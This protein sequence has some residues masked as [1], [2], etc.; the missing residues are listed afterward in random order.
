MKLIPRPDD[1]VVSPI[2]DPLMTKGGLYIPENAR[3]K[4]DQGIIISIGNEVREDLEIGDH[5]IFPA[6]AGYKIA[7]EEGGE[8]VILKEGSI[9]GKITN[10]DT[11]L[12]DTKTMERLVEELAGDM[13][14]KFFGGVM[15]ELIDQF[16]KELVERI[17]SR[18]YSEG[19]EF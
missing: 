19:L 1:I 2:Y 5:I 13:K 11:V 12:I 14:V 16:G 17:K 8:Y 18:I 6:Y 9:L 3:Q 7:F 10:S 4:A 15:D